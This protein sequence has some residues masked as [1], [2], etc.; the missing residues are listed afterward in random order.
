ME[1]TN[2]FYSLF[3]NSSFKPGCLKIGISGHRLL[4]HKT[5]LKKSLEQ[6]LE[7][8][9]EI[10]EVSRIKFYSPLAEGADQIA[11][12]LLPA[13][14]RIDL[15]VPLPLAEENYL[16]A[17]KTQ[18][19][20]K[21]FS[22]LLT[23]AKSTLQLPKVCPEQN[24][25]VELGHFLAKE[26]DLMIAV[27]NGEEAFGPGGTGDVIRETLALGKPVCWIYANNLKRGAKNLLDGSLKIG[28]IRI[29]NSHKDVPEI[30]F[31]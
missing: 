10:P 3:K 14:N 23:T 5:I 7:D 22:R 29:L 1:N 24:V 27:W 2:I 19:G 26:V 6:I 12:A 4:R 21:N 31:T 20:R 30:F 16:T 13:Y 18:K 25:Y 15:V 17:F 9:L 8:L 11:A 28:E